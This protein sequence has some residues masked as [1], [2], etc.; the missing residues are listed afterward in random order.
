MLVTLSLNFVH[1]FVA[2]AAQAA[3]YATYLL[4]SGIAAVTM[5][6]PPTPLSSIQLNSARCLRV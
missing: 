1:V 4:V 5:P 6:S 2:K 3:F